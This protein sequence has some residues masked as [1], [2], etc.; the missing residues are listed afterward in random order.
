MIFDL[1][2]LKRQRKQETEKLCS[3]LVLK[4]LE[5]ITGTVKDSTK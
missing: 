4:T 1:S 5:I 2:E 3:E